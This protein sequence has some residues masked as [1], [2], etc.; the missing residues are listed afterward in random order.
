MA[1]K[2][3]LYDVLVKLAS[4]EQKDKYKILQGPLS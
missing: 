1:T 3:Q 2:Q 4:P